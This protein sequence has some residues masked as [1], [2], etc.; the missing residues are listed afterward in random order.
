M[1]FSST[2]AFSV[3]KVDNSENFAAGGIINR[4]TY[5]NSLCRDKNKH[6]MASSV[7]VYEAMDHVMLPRMHEVSPTPTLVA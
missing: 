2:R 7:M 1:D 5:H 6:Y 4:R 3:K